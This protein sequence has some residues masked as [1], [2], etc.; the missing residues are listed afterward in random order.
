MA[1]G[2]AS[3]REVMMRGVFDKVRLR[4]HLAPDVESGYTSCA[5]ATTTIYRAAETGTPMIVITG[6]NNGADP[7]RSRSPRPAMTGDPCRTCV[8]GVPCATPRSPSAPDGG[9]SRVADVGEA[10]RFLADLL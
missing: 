3:N 2:D 10:D 9:R 5:G 1:P 4:N 6:R 7:F 8:R